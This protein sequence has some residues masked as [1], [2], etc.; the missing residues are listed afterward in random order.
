MND[1]AIKTSAPLSVKKQA[2]ERDM[3]LRKA[4]R[5]FE[6]VFTYEILKNM[7]NS[8]EK[9]DLFHGGQAEDI[10]QSMLDQQ[11]AKNMAGKGPNSIANIL[12]QQLKHLD[13][14]EGN[15]NTVIDNDKS[16]P[17]WPLNGRI[18]S[19]FGWRKDPFTGKKKFH[20]GIDLAAKEGTN[21]KA[22]MAGKVLVTDDQSGYGKVVVL[23]NGHGLT[24]LYAHNSDILVKTGDW[25]KKGSTIAK[26][27][28]TGRSTGPHLH[29]E[30]RK[31][32]KR[33]D[34]EKFLK[35]HQA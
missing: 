35:V 2:D 13:Q 14:L 24:T 19:S 17:E 27:G 32:G 21:V 9:C 20:D 25:V 11:L 8:V 1:I 34:P 28:S 3:K 23:D 5:D 29:F 31:D 10:Y 15:G 18:S 16:L 30:V 7:R 26:V 12:Y 4:C 33:L 22:S 6:S